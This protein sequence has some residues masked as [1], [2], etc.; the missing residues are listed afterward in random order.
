[1]PNSQPT[2]V[3]I[4]QSAIDLLDNLMDHVCFT[5]ASEQ[6]KEEKGICYISHLLMQIRDKLARKS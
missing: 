3:M 1:M 2:E 5:E 6:C 4:L